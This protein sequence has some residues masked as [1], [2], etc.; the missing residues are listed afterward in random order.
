[1]GIITLNKEPIYGTKNG[2]Y[3]NGI[4]NSLIKMNSKNYRERVECLIIKGNKVFLSINPNKNKPY[5]IPGGS[6]EPGI[7]LKEQLQNECNEEAKII[8]SNPKFI[9]AYDK[10]YAHKDYTNNLPFEYD[11]YLCYLY[12]ANYK[13]PYTGFI[14][15]EDLDNDM[16]N[17]GK[18]Y[19]ISKIYYKLN[20]YH[21]IA[22]KEYLPSYGIESLFN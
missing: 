11:A 20:E 17:Y 19:D 21:K 8:I 9:L 22:L 2:A 12:I 7:T 13:A 6:S 1:M 18:F 5:K 15:D 16:Y 14:K 4:W 10:D 3:N